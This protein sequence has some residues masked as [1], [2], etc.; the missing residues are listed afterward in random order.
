MSQENAAE[1][2][3]LKTSLSPR[4]PADQCYVFVKGNSALMSDVRTCGWDHNTAPNT[5]PEFVGYSC[6]VTSRVG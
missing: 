4:S 5:G 2:P 3:G 1:T 6:V